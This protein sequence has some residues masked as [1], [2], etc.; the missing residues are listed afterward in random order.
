MSQHL[1]RAY[2]FS[3][4]HESVAWLISNS[5]HSAAYCYKLGPNGVKADKASVPRRL[6]PYSNTL[7]Q[8]QLKM[9][10]NGWQFKCATSSMH[11]NGKKT[12]YGT[13]NL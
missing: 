8:Q 4:H 10:E 1:N 5:P 13:T 11:K 9:G 3:D 7:T 12:F 6:P 2:A